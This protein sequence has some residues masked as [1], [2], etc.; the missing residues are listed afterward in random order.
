MNDYFILDDDHN[1]IAADLMTW[2]HWF[3]NAENR[4]VAKTQVGNCVVSTVCLGIDHNF[5]R[6]GRPLLFETMVFVD[7]NDEDCWRSSTWAEAVAQ[8]E[9]VVD[10]MR[11]MLP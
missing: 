2:S 7:G 4:V 9:R 5:M 6:D 1:L 10:E 11:E 3:E 8:H